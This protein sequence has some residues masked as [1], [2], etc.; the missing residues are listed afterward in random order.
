MRLECLVQEKFV[1]LAESTIAAIEKAGP[2]ARGRVRL[3]VGDITAPGLGLGAP[4]AKALRARLTGCHHLA[5]VYDLAV[6]RE[7]GM[8][9]NVE[10][11]RNVLEF[12][13]D[14]PKL[15]RLDYVS[16]A[17]VSGTAVGI[18]RESDLDVGQKFKNFYEE[19]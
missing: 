2:A 8:R 12:L 5:A 6:S 7:L 17:F 16:T 13:S 18:Y 10:G 1:P 11:T 4:E 14:A 19:S 3:V 9:I 15:R